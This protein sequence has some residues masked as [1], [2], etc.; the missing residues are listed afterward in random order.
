MNRIPKYRCRGITLIEIL[1]TLGLLALLV[2]FA[3][4]AFSGA[5][6]RADMREASDILQFSIRIARNSAR[7]TESIVSINLLGKPG[8]TGQH[9][10]FSASK[11]AQ[12]SLAHSG[13]QDYQFDEEIKI[14]SD[15][16][17]YEFDGRGIV[18]NPGQITLISRTDESVT[19]QIMV[20]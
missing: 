4:P 6:T 18:K 9:I 20:E 3:S 14:I 19:T 10:S 17:V 7:T 11:L 2:F 13:L 8:E 12:K 16:P 15:F 1:L 5:T